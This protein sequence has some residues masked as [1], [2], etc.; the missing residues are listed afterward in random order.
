MANGLEDVLDKIA[1]CATIQSLVDAWDGIVADFG[2]AGFTYIDARRVPASH[3]GL[4]YHLTTAPADFIAAYAGSGY[5]S[6]DPAVRRGA[7]SNAPFTWLDCPE[8]EGF[9]TP[10]RGARSKAV[11]IMRNACDFGFTQGYVIPCHAVDALGRPASAFFSL[12]WRHRP[13]TLGAGAGMPPWL[14]LAAA[15]VHERLLPLRGVPAPEP[16]RPALTD[17][18]RECLAWAACGKTRGETADILAIR[19]R[20]VEF[21][22]GNAMKKLG[23]YNKFHAIAVAIQRGLISP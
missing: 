23:V 22:F 18:E 11:E 14:R 7:T 15:T 16:A 9:D 4:P 3:P 10:R 20:M 21:H 12:P 2:F 17:R 6:H 1:G 13:E 19:E 8:F 5:F